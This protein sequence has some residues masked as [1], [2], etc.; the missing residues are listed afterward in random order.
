MDFYENIETN[1]MLSIVFMN[2]KLNVSSPIYGTRGKC[3]YYY[4]FLVIVFGDII[5]IIINK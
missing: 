4:C 5:H 3:Y 2:I 1:I